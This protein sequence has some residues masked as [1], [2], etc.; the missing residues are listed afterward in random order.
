MSD[1][2]ANLTK[3]HLDLPNHWWLKGE[4]LWA[5]RL[6]NDLYEIQNIPCCAYGLNFGDVVRATSDAPD[7]KPEVRA[8]VTRSGNRTARISFCDKLSKEQQQPVLVTLVSMGTE[9]E[10]ATFKFVC[11][12]VPPS[13]SY[14]SVCTYLAEQEKVGSLE[15]ETC[16]ERVPGSFDD[17]PR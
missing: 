10:R 1:T 2:D 16:E 11:V 9:I 4:S 12:S 7:L 17:R 15:Y 13:V 8:V 3:V 6:G 14:D 5:K